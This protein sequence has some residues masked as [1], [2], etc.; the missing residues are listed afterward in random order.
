M[1]PAASKEHPVFLYISIVHLV[2]I[3]VATYIVFQFEEFRVLLLDVLMQSEQN[4]LSYFVRLYLIGVV[5]QLMGFPVFVIEVLNGYLLQNLLLSALLNFLFKMTAVSLAFFFSKN[6]IRAGMTRVI[7]SSRKFRMIKLLVE[8]NP[9][10]MF[11]I[12]RIVSL[13]PLVHD[14]GPGI[15][16]VRF[17]DFASGFAVIIGFFAVFY[18]LIGLGIAD[19]RES[20]VKNGDLQVGSVVT[21]FSLVATFVISVLVVRYANR[22]MKIEE[23]K[24]LQ[25]ERERDEAKAPTAPTSL[26]AGSGTEESTL[27]HRRH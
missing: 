22:E 16:N 1:K 9:F 18:S 24:E 3:S 19:I 17:L 14:Y 13:P 20:Y 10:R 15:F 23:A 25:L 6:F 27:A 7:N 21:Y 26:A 4:R 8:K 5:S 11:M 2:L 12:Y